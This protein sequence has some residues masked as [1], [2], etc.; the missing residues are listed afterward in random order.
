MIRPVVGTVLSRVVMAVVNLL[1]IVAAGQALGAEGLGTIS[2]IV[3]G[4]TIILLFTHIVGGGGLVYLIPRYGVRPLL[5]PSYAWVLLCAVL[6]YLVQQFIPLVPS[7]FVIHIVILASLQGL[8]SIH[9]G[10]LLGRERI[11][12]LNRIM[13]VQSIV[14]LAA[15]ALLL[16][17]G[18]AS[19]MDYVLA[20]YFAHGCTVVISGSFALQRLESSQ[21]RPA[22]VLKALFHQG[23]LAQGA[24][25]LQLLNYRF[26]YYLI[27]HFRG[28]AALGIFSVTTQLAESTWLVPKSIGGVLYSKVSNLVE[29]ERQR[30]LTVILLKVSVAV[31]LVSC[32]ALL[33]VPDGVYTWIFG[34]E[35]S[36]LRPI[37]VRMAPGLVAMS[38]S[39]VLSHYLSGTGRIKH[40]T[41]GSGIGLVITV[42]VGFWLIPASGLEGAAITASLAYGLSVCYQLIVFRRVTGISWAELIPHSGDRERAMRLWDRFKQRLVK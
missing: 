6:A 4:I 36:G 23:T 5:A 10:I 37:L 17:M 33:L 13:V 7:E 11:G 2:L 19:V 34:P 3:L 25:I 22:G 21:M 12:L 8:N 16:G 15:F 28:R 35:I 41:I 26:A 38:A 39:Q 24:N 27:E 31:A 1:V 20:T 32:T 9:L 40:N 29:A 18:R 42:L 30:D 14:Q